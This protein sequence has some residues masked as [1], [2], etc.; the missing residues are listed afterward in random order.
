MAAI[1][2]NYDNNNNNAGLSVQAV[3]KNNQEVTQ[4][5]QQLVKDGNRVCLFIGRTPKENLPQDENTIWVSLDIKNEVE[6]KPEKY[7][8]ILNCNDMNQMATIQHLFSKVIVDQSTWKFFDEGIFDRLLPLLTQHPSSTFTFESAF[9]FYQPEEIE[10]WKFDH[11]TLKYPFTED[12]AYE[13]Q[14]Q[15]YVQTRVAELGGEEQLSSNNEYKQFIASLDQSLVSSSTEEELIGDFKNHLASQANIPSP[16]SKYIPLARQQTKD[17]LQTLFD[18][19][20]LHRKEA[21]PF[22]NGNYS[23]A[24]DFFVA[25]GPKKV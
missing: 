25:I 16:L 1:S 5:I 7:H 15:V 22:D 18:T 2:Q 23:K 9:Q 12:I 19:V 8:L 3:D 11:V 6:L 4:E 17:Y 13:N 20:E 14:K 10:E 24:A 21:F